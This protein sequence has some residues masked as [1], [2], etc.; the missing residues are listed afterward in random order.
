M[1]VNIYIYTYYIQL[2][3][4]I[5]GYTYGCIYMYKYIIIYMYTGQIE[6]G[7]G[8]VKLTS[9]EITC[10][11]KIRSLVTHQ[12]PVLNYPSLKRVMDWEAIYIYTRQFGKM[13]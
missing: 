9:L 13:T 1:A 12:S 4:Y 11:V 6:T 7:N 5:D 8:D 2:C 3:I 10:R